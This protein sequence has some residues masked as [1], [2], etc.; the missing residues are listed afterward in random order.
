[1]EAVLYVVLDF[2]ELPKRQQ[3]NPFRLPME[4]E[5]ATTQTSRRVFQAKGRADLPGRMVR[6][7]CRY[8]AGWIGRPFQSVTGSCHGILG[9]L[10]LGF[11]GDDGPTLRLRVA[12]YLRKPGRYYLRE[13]LL[14]AEFPSDDIVGKEFRDLI[15]VTV[16]Q[17]IVKAVDKLIVVL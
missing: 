6:Q 5:A 17:P 9:Q 4:C 14:P 8:A 13:L 15:D 11:C 1:M 2:A 7:R 10:L 16:F 12:L 3:M